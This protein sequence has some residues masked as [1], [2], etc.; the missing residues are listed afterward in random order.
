M[1]KTK[2]LYKKNTFYFMFIALFIMLWAVYIGMETFKWT[3]IPMGESDDYM[4]TTVSLQ[5]CGELMVREETLIHAK[6]D[7][8]EFSEYLDNCYEKGEQSQVTDD[9]GGRLPW[10]FGTYSAMCIPAKILLKHI[11]FPQIYA[12]SLTN[13]IIYLIALLMVAFA[14]KQSFQTRFFLLLLLGINPALFY[15][16]WQSAE[17]F[18]FGF[19]IISLVL[20]VNKNYKSA[21]FFISVAG[22]MN[23]TVMV[24][25]GAMIVDYFI[26]LLGDK[27]EENAIGH[28]LHNWRRIIIYGCCYIPC[29]IPFI[30]YKANYGIWNLQVSYGFADQGEN[31]FSRVLS[32]FF[33]WNYGVLP[34]FPILLILFV[35]LTIIMVIKRDWRT[36]LF[37]VAFIGVVAAYSIMYHINCGMSGMARYTA[38]SVPIMLFAVALMCNNIMIQRKVLKKIYN[39]CMIASVIYSSFV[40]YT[41]GIMFACNTSDI[42]LTP[43]AEK[44]I[45]NCP[46]LYWSIPS[47]FVDRVEHVPGGYNYKEPVIYANKEGVVRK[48]LVT[49]E[50]A[51][52][53]LDYIITDYEGE[54]YIQSKIDGFENDDQYYFINIPHRYSIYISASYVLQ[55]NNVLDQ[56]GIQLQALSTTG[57]YDEESD[58]IILNEGEV[59]FGPY[60]TLSAGKYK[61]I[62]CGENLDD[63]EVHLSSGRGDMTSEVEIIEKNNDIVIYTFEIEE[64]ARNVEFL[65]L[66]MKNK[67]IMISSIFIEVNDIMR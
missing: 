1:N 56:N 59:Q 61:I 65:V 27:K 17:I 43:I 3:P 6:T 26:E 13:F 28:L 35:L 9:K 19:V 58:V 23:S 49:G 66:N 46:Q 50:N 20:W 11:G 53:I 16:V 47:S 44:I 55:K 34:Y 54:R 18:I 52:K 41:Y 40:I 8:P 51:K 57:T 62:V 25:G 63:A 67:P 15:I 39:I 4:F 12:Y 36:V 5:Y 24:L 31:Y 64:E 33:D 60:I 45:D 22:T 32:Y 30:Y 38:W 2:K 10:Y 29:L 48:I 14:L 37:S 7:F 21:A 42:Y